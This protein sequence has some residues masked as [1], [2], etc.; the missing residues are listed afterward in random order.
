MNN[1]SIYDLIGVGFGPSN[2][3]LAVAASELDE[4]KQCLF[5]EKSASL[6]WHPGMLIEGARMQISFLKDLATMRNPGS[7]YS[8]LQYLKDKGRLEHFIN[9]REFFPT[10]FEYQ[11]YLQWVAASFAHQVHYATS[12]VNVTPVKHNQESILSVEVQNSVTKE[13]AIYYTRNIVYGAGGTQRKLEGEMASS[14]KIIQSKHFLFNFPNQFKD[15][16]IPYSFSVVGDGQS[17]SEIVT[18]IMNHYPQAQINLYISNVSL[19][20]V[21]DNPF[22]NEQFYAENKEFF[23]NSSKKAR[24]AMLKDVQSTNYG[25]TDM[26]DLEG[27]Y[28]LVYDESVKGIS[29]LKIHPYSKLIEVTEKGGQIHAHI[30]NRINNEVAVQNCDGIVLATGYTRSLNQQMF[31]EVMPFLETTPEGNPTYTKNYR[32]KTN[33]NVDWGVYLQGYCETSFGVGDT[34]LS[35]LPFRSQEI[36]KDICEKIPATQNGYSLE[37]AAQGGCSFAKAALSAQN[38][39]N[40]S[41]VAQSNYPPKHFLEK[42]REKLFEVI[43]KFKFATLISVQ[44]D[45]QPIVTQ[46]PLILDRTR[47]KNGVL[48]GHFD[49]TNPQ[50]KFLNN[51]KTLVVFHGPEAYISPDLFDTSNLPTWNFISVQV[52]GT[53]N[54][55]T[56]KDAVVRGL[57]GIAELSEKNNA[58]SY[59]LDPEDPRIDQLIDYIVGFEIE[60]EKMVGRFKLSQDKKESHRKKAALYLAEKTEAGQRDFIEGMVEISLPSPLTV[61]D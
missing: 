19:H 48:F 55:L 30:R 57:C 13:R 46:L 49:K 36:F 26:E 42:D 22:I 59:R 5:F 54:V 37:K 24:R 33:T 6:Q 29:R 1:S 11:D 2:L 51:Q 47:G 8:F 56:D 16:T 10:R 39:S 20:A 21:D 52:H 58:G 40:T 50:V 23:Y 41:K 28:N 32:L 17:A 53:V 12:V 18:Y 27:L 3:A 9:L 4:T 31:K 34:L 14:A 7:P 61:V 44:A 43:D 38:G 45:Q 60:I 25:V 15:T 35:H